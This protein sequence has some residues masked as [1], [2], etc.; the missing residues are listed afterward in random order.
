MSTTVLRRQPETSRGW[1]S[2]KLLDANAELGV[3]TVKVDLAEVTEAEARVRAAASLAANALM[4]QVFA[5][6]LLGLDII[7]TGSNLQVAIPD[8]TTVIVRVSLASELPRL[9]AALWSNRR[10][11]PLVTSG[12]R[13]GPSIHLDNTRVGPEVGGE[14][15]LRFDT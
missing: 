5:E 4:G 8:R 1:R 14:H 3:A 12:A 7:P 6:R 11:G 15:D 10:S 9:L 13:N 2:T